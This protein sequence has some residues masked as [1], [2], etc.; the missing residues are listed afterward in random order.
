M[1]DFLGVSVLQNSTHKRRGKQDWVKG[2][3][4]L[5]L[6]PSGGSELPWPRLNPGHLVSMLLF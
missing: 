5:S 2:E 6:A 1:Q 4:E 3:G